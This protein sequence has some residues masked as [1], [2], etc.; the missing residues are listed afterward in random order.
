MSGIVGI[1]SKKKYKN[2]FPSLYSA[3]YALQHRGQESMGLSLLSHEKL[4]EIK[5]DGDIAKNISLDNISTL[6]GNIGLGHVRYSFAE[7]D[8]S[9]LPMPWL[10]YPEN[11]NRKNLIAIDGKFIDN[12]SPEEI[13]NKLN[14][15][16]IDE[17]INFVENLKGAYSILVVNEKRMIAIRDPYGIKN[18]C[19]G[20]K[21]DDFIV[22]SETCAIESIDGEVLHELKPGEIYIVDDQGEESY[23]AKEISNSPCIFEF[24]YTARPDSCI[25]GISVYDSRIKMGEILY[26]EHP[27]DADIVVGSPDSGL[28]SALGFSRAS[29][30]K[31]ERAILR[32]RYINRTFILPTNSMRKKGIKI[33]LNP[34]KH[35]IE[36]KRIVLIDDSIVRGN[37]IK[38]VIEILRESGAKEVHIRVASPQVIKEENFTFDVADKDHLISNNRSVEEVRKIIGAD[39]LGFIS[40][41]GLR[42]ACGNKTYYENCFNGNNPLERI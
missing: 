26:K 28:I 9:L 25:N 35:L 11:E 23:F 41:E 36:G 4:S 16:N 10:F 37:T 2:I 33:K 27:V 21:D 40:L 18:L 30:I 42:K 8:S 39:S 24:V 17:I 14:S 5:G 12:I 32:N 22:A 19:V 20:K 1:Y 31:Y 38:R 34:I 7:D 6:A 29:K 3:L 15:N 13:I